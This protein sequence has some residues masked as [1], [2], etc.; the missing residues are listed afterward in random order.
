MSKR[1]ERLSNFTGQGALVANL[2]LFIEAARSRDEPLDHVLFHGPPGLGKTTLSQL[3]SEEM[4]GKLVRSSAPVIENQRTLMSL[5]CSLEA[6]DVLFIDEIHRLP[7]AVEEVLYTVMED[8]RLDL[9]VGEGMEA[10]AVSLDLDPFTLVGAT[11]RAGGLSRPLFDRFPIVM[12]LDYYDVDEMMPILKTAAKREGIDLG[13]TLETVA[14]RC[15]GT[16]RVANRLISRIRDF[17]ETHRDLPPSDLVELVFDRMSIGELGL[18]G[19][20][21]RYLEF[22]AST[23]R[24]VGLSTIAAAIAETPESI[25]DVIEP[26]LLRKGLVS[27]TQRGRELTEAGVKY[28]GIEPSDKRPVE[29]DAVSVVL[30]DSSL[31]GV[32]VVSG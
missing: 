25:E 3:I 22:L 30:G 8:R 15:R 4:G 5:L 11:T 7:T 10:R 17:A 18:D 31:V 26:F 16:P 32:P 20:D 28:L 1:P 14:S 23:G 2:K 13:G 21:L 19:E 12:R 24:P 29:E 6:G 27:R 9:M